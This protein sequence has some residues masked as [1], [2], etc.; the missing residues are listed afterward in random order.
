MS[1]YFLK[2]GGWVKIKKIICFC[3]IVLF[4]FSNNNITYSAPAG[5]TVTSG[6][7]TI[8]QE[9]SKTTINQNSQKAIVEWNSFNIQKNE[10]VH[11]QQPNN[12]MI[13]NRINPQQ[14]VSKIFGLL[15]ATGQVIL[16]NQAGIFFAPGSMVNVGSIIASTTD[17]TN[18]NF[19]NNKLIFDQRSPEYSGVIVNQGSI[20]TADYGLVALIGNTVDNDGFIDANLGQ[21]IL[22][23]GSKFTMD[24]QDDGLPLLF[25]ITDNAAN[26]SVDQNGNPVKPGVTHTGSI[27]ANGGYVYVAAK[28]VGEVIDNVINM[29]GVVSA[30]SIQEKNGI[31][32]LSSEGTG[33][34]KISGKIEASGKNAGEKGGKITATGQ[35]MH[36]AEGA[37]I[38][39]SGDQGGGEILIGGDT[40]GKGTLAHATKT[41]VESNTRILSNA[42]TKGDGGKI[43]VW[44]DEATGA[45]GYISAR[46]GNQS[47]NGGFVETSGAGLDVYS[48]Q[49]DV[50]APH[51]TTGTWLLD[52]TNVTISNSA[53][54]DMVFGGGQYSP[55][56]IS[57][58]NANLNAANLGSQ[59]ATANIT[60]VTTNILG[61]GVGNITVTG[62]TGL[63]ANWTSGAN[64]T[65]TLQADNDIISRQESVYQVVGK[66]SFSMSPMEETSPSMAI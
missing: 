16:V 30:N 23:S 13:L 51:G 42:I 11:F 40:Y 34:V 37:V 46:G 19:L 38:D 6:T 43:V 31:I 56:I 1:I 18:S 14:G 47:G 32:I 50:T 9:G 65:L 49:I 57:I 21:V 22:A 28:N 41:L 36:I 58:A 8:N 5:G 48:M 44:S 60:V 25:T 53:T 61:L 52:P 27:I 2:K 3:I 10:H 7:A 35:Y 66:V 62:V 55:S 63:D 33:T 4:A 24:F 45:Y 15:T 20:K 64:T 54:N 59:L 29:Q 12:G 26:I 17:I 39:V